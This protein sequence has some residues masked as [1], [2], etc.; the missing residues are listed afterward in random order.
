M[1]AHNC[2]FVCLDFVKSHTSQHSFVLVNPSMNTW[3]AIWSFPFPY[4]III[5]DLTSVQQWETGDLLL[6][7][8]HHVLHHDWHRLTSLEGGGSHSYLSFRRSWLNFTAGAEGLSLCSLHVLPLLLQASCS[9]SG[10]FFFFLP[11]NQKHLSQVDI[12][13]FA[14]MKDLQLIWFLWSDERRV[15]QIQITLLCEQQS[16]F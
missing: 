8:F 15:V 2:N 16:S 9:C 7:T 12:K 14:M 11:Y 13:T 10:L 4:L 6:L 1:F 3:T 5:T